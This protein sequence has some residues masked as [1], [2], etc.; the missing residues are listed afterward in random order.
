[1]IK[2]YRFVI[3]AKAGIF[4][5]LMLIGCEDTSSPMMGN[6]FIRDFLLKINHLGGESLSAEEDEE[7]VVAIK[8]A[9][10]WGEE[11]NSWLRQKD[12]KKEADI[13]EIEKKWQELL[14]FRVLDD[15]PKR[16]LLNLAGS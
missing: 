6:S 13:F 14:S 5:L 16:N 1:M 7:F 10:E 4:L 9:K 12:E 15:H 2:D 11:V 8:Q 3:P